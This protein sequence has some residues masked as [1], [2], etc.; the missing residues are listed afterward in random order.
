[1]ISDPARRQ[2]ELAAKYAEQTLAVVAPHGKS[3]GPETNEEA[4]VRTG[5]GLVKYSELYSGVRQ[6]KPKKRHKRFTWPAHGFQS[7]DPDFAEERMKDI[8]ASLKTLVNATPPGSMQD[9]T[10]LPQPEKESEKDGVQ[11][12][13]GALGLLLDAV[14]P[15][16]PQ[17]S[18][19][20]PP[21]PRLKKMSLASRPPWLR[22]K[23]ERLKIPEPEK[24]SE[25]SNFQHKSA[26]FT[27]TGADYNLTALELSKMTTVP[28][29][30]SPLSQVY[31]TE[32]LEPT[33]PSC[34]P[35]RSPRLRPSQPSISGS[36]NSTRPKAP[37]HLLPFDET[38]NK[39]EALNKFAPHLR[40]QPHAADP[41]LR[42]FPSEP[43][44]D[45][46]IKIAVGLGVEIINWKISPEMRDLSYRLEL[47]RS[48]STPL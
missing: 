13:Q 15:K 48:S 41:E 43:S 5:R 8:R 27:R 34:S 30:S 36:S 33:T 22:E 12:Y 4:M 9:P 18:M 44:A 32:S 1:M 46:D 42:I 20:P 10:V 31:G 26:K 47:I 39:M 16:T 37:F 23:L 19:A 21:S 35:P 2:G 3:W 7:P 25:R 14:L 11:D 28:S 17:T 45:L 24:A 6:P 29:R 40:L 38:L